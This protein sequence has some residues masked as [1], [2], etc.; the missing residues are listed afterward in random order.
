ELLRYAEY[1]DAAESNSRLIDGLAAT[2]ALSADH[3]IRSNPTALPHAY[4]ARRVTFLADDAATRSALFELDPNE[5]TLVTGP[6]RALESDPL[7]NA[8]VVERAAD[9][10]TIH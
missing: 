9:L 6:P 4:F 1:I 7:A 10:L 2:H 8:T 5:N 3:A